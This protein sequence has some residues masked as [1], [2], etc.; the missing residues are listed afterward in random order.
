MT[1]SS[2]GTQLEE[3]ANVVKSLRGDFEKG[4]AREIE[5][6]SVSSDP[7]KYKGTLLKSSVYLIEASPR[8]IT[9]GTSREDIIRG[10]SAMR[11]DS[12]QAAQKAVDLFWS[13]KRDDK[14]TVTYGVVGANNFIF[15]GVEK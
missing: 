12:M 6:D 5:F 9:I 8:R 11:A 14:V 3:Y 15:F 2:T 10:G 13:L 7:E 1:P 4:S